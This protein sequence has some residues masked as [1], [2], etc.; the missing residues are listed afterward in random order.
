MMEETG[1]TAAWAGFNIMLAAGMIR[2]AAA[3]DHP[4]NRRGYPV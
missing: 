2:E 3:I 4:D 1:A